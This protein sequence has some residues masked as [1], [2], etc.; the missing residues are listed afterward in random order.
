[1]GC[2]VVFQPSGCRGV[3]EKGKRL[4][5]AARELRV[6]LVAPCGGAETC[7][8]C[9]VKIEEGI[10]A[11]LGTDSRMSHLSP[12]SEKEK[13]VLKPDEI[14]GNIRLACSTFITGDVLVSIPE[15]SRGGAQVILAS[16]EERKYD[17]NPAVKKYCIEIDKPTLSDCRDDY[18]RLTDALKSRYQCFDKEISVDYLVL[19]NLPA[20]LR[21]SDWRLTATVWDNSEI[22]DLEPGYSNKAYGIAIDLGTTTIAAYLCDLSSG[23]VLKR[24]SMVNSQICYGDDVISRI[25]YC[26]TNEDGLQKLHDIAINDINT[27]IGRLAASAGIYTGNIYE[28]VMVFNTAMHHIALNIDPR[29]MGRAPFPSAIRKPMDLKARD[30]NIGISKCGNVHCL[31]VEA[32]FVGPDNVAVLI[33][34]Q[35]HKQEKMMLVIDIGTNGELALGNSSGMLSASCA[36]GPA[37]E[38]AQIKFGMRAAQGAIE[39]VRIDPDNLEPEIKVIGEDPC[40]KL[41]TVYARGICGSGIIDAVAQ[42]FITGII[43]PDGRFNKALESKRVRKDQS[44]KY[45]YVLAWVE[46]SS[47]EKDITITQKDVR[48]VQLAK[49]ALYAG[50]KILMKK[51][52]VDKIDRVVLAGAFGSYI[53]K[54]SALA[55][56]MFPDCELENICAVGN[57][58]GEGARLALLD[59]GKRR[60]AKE[61]AKFVQFVETAAE[62]DF[63]NHFYN[64]MNF[65]HA[66]DT[67][68][69]FENNKNLA[70]S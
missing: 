40:N 61:A 52:G 24:D 34:E 33:A 60:E 30:L 43:L 37:L 21:G 28:A 66:I 64:A 2:S 25:T 11:G 65:P 51:R 31:P 44:G 36:T 20:L 14:K 62:A 48:A 3:F 6:D 68:K 8:K 23:E 32:G 9:K 42:M 16:G 56:G 67:F 55:I 7:G 53:N 29:S 49:A 15:E 54:E 5:E 47:T 38:G 46:D 17:L 1:M 4:F 19:K 10:F 39:K 41:K 35:P 27:L 13:R 63:Q 58:A 59:V 26:M 45:E 57:A 12:L 18:E 69:N 50:A 70:M 22:I